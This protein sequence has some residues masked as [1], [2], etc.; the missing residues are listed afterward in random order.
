[1]KSRTIDVIEPIAGVERQQ[2]QFGTF[3]EIRRL[4]NDQPSAANTC[5]DGHDLSVSSQE[6]PNKRLQPTPSGAIGKAAS[7]HRPARRYSASASSSNRTRGFTAFEVRLRRV[8]ERLPKA[9]RRTLQ[10]SLCGH[11]FR[12]QRPTLPRLRRGSRNR[13]ALATWR[14][15]P[16]ARARPRGRR[17]GR[18]SPRGTHTHR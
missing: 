1:M 18:S 5:L 16:P 6:P 15:P 7:Y 4:V 3:G 14:L 17:A 13:E 8:V 10:P 9:R 2:F 12:F 11:V